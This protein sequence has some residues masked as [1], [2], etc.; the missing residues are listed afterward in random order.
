MKKAENVDG[1][2]KNQFPSTKKPE[3]VDGS[4]KTSSR[5]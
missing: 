4:I 5:P 3:N 1:S 2:I